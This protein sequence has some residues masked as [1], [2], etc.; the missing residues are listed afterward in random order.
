MI[1]LVVRTGGKASA[2]DPASAPPTDSA[3]GLSEKRRAREAPT[4]GAAGAANHGAKHLRAGCAAS[5]PR[6]GTRSA[7]I[8]DAAP[9]LVMPSKR[10]ECEHAQFYYTTSP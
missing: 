3:T 2:G 10:I 7:P 4:S 5:G 6:Q 1:P 8:L 9:I